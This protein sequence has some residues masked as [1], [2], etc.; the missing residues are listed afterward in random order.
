MKI[1]V[2]CNYKLYDPVES[3]FIHQQAVAYVKL[4]HQVKVLVPIPFGR[5][6]ADGKHPKTLYYTKKQDG[7]ELIYLRF[8]SFSKLG[9]PYLNHACMSAAFHCA[10]QSLFRD[11]QP[12]VIHA[13]A[14]STTGSMG[15][16]L[17]QRLGCPLVMTTHGSDTT[18]AV[19][20]GKLTA[21]KELCDQANHVVAVSSVLSKKLMSCG[22]QTPVSV[23]LNGFHV[24]ALPSDK[25]KKQLASI[26]QVSNLIPQ[27]HA[28]TTL[29]AFAGLK[30]VYP[31][32]NIT[33]VGQ[34][35]DWK[36][37]EVLTHELGISDSV[38]FTGQLPNKEV[39]AEMAKAQFFCMPSVR[40]GFG[41]VYLEAMASGCI[42]IGTEGE[43]IADLIENGKNGFL[44]PPDDPDAIV[45]VMEWCL[46]NPQ[47][48]A[49][50]AQ[51]GK[52]DA[53]SL[54]WQANA[55]QYL[56]LFEEL[57]K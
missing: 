52:Q 32:A 26:I 57:C 28:D 25:P 18:I 38:R 21:L 22:T 24:Q 16:W 20:H 23:I 56:K 53:M 54:T 47:E 55:A 7:V 8:F 48:A 33:I 3:S 40:E 15:I 6:D 31:K 9:D 44:V 29:Y 35:E 50:I 13:H 14:F 41:I 49:V 27:K 34:G 36:N 11:F 2:L 1:L 45:Q 51:Q 4:G 46:E 10:Q 12:D 5:K 42:T 19:E 30:K 39:L 17:K 43:G 37:L